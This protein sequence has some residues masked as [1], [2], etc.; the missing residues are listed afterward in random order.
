MKTLLTVENIDINITTKDGTT[1]LWV[2]A[3][4]GHY[5]VV[6]LLI[7]AQANVNGALI[8]QLPAPVKLKL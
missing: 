5:K 3:H 4:N 7:K 2:S 1:A 8:S 6:D